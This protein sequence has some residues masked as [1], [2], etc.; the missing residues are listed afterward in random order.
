LVQWGDLLRRLEN[1]NRT[2]LPLGNSEKSIPFLRIY[3]CGISDAQ[4]QPMIVD[5]VHGL[6]T[7]IRYKELALDFNLQGFYA[8]LVKDPGNFV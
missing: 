5:N 6:L 4:K 3:D 2:N 7:G 1:L 8:N